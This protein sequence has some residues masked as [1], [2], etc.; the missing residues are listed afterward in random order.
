[1]INQG[2]GL[3]IIWATVHIFVFVCVCVSREYIYIYRYRTNIYINMYFVKSRRK[4]IDACEHYY[5]YIYI[6]IY[7]YTNT[8]TTTTL[9]CHC[10]LLPP[11][12]GDST[13]YS[14]TLT[15]Y[16]V[17]G[18]DSVRAWWLV[19]AANANEQCLLY[20]IYNWTTQRSQHTVAHITYVIIIIIV[21]C[22]FF[23]FVPLNTH[24]YNIYLYIYVWLFSIYLSHQCVFVFDNR[25]EL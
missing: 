19:A 14:W 9:A 25:S 12:G 21:V 13:A 8:L 6:Y 4:V 7:V 18:F 22:Y 24:K 20:I 5:E 1:M 10:M 2:R 3:I 15:Q 17:V 23:C 16:S 11:T